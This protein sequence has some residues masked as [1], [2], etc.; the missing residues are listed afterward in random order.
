M[1]KCVQR[2][3]QNGFSGFFKIFQKGKWRIMMEY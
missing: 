1:R 3:E 2:F